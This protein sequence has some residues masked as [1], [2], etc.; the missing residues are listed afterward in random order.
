MKKSEDEPK[1]PVARMRDLKA[2]R[3]AARQADRE[4]RREERAE[5]RSA[6]KEAAKAAPT[7]AVPTAATADA[8]TAPPPAPKSRR[9]SW[10]RRLVVVPLIVLFLLVIACA[11]AALAILYGATDEIGARVNSYQSD[12]EIAVAGLS[13]EVTIRRDNGGVPYVYAD[14]YPDALFGQGFALGQDRLFQLELARRLA[15]GRLSEIAGSET[16]SA[17]RMAR[18]L[19]LRRLAEARLAVLDAPS[20]LELESFAA[21]VSAAIAARPEDL[22]LA[23]EFAGLG[24]PRAWT[25]LDVLSIVY[26]QSWYFASPAATAELIAQGLMERF[27]GDEN[28]AETFF[29]IS[30]NPDDPA[31]GEAKTI[32]RAESRRPFEDLDLNLRV[33]LWGQRRDPRLGAA[34][35]GAS[36]EG[37]SNNWAFSGAR[38]GTGRAIVANDPHLDARRLPGPWHPVGLITKDGVRAV[39]ANIGLPGIVVGRTRAA[40]FG[41]TIGYADAVDLF[42]EIVDPDRPGFYRDGADGPWLRAEIREE[43]IRIRDGDGFR[44]ETL[45]VTSTPRGPLAPALGLVRRPDRALSIRWAMASPE[46][47][48]RTRYVSEPLARA[49]G[50]PAVLRAA[51]ALAEV[52]LN[53]VAGDIDGRIGRRATGFLP[54][55]EGGDGLTPLPAAAAASAWR[56]FAAGADLPGEE[57]PEPGWTG[58]A[59]HFTPDAAFPH[60][61]SD[62]HAPSH[63][64]ERMKSLF[65][66][67]GRLSPRLAEAAQRDVLNLFASRLVPVIVAALESDPERRD[68]SALA[69]EILETWDRRD[70]ATAAAPLIFQ[71]II[72]EAAVS[73]YAP[74]L[75]GALAEKMLSARSFW[76]QRFENEIL[77]GAGPILA[78]AGFEGVIGRDVL[79]RQAT[80]AA[81]ERLATLHEG[82][83][84]RWRWGDALA[85]QFQGPIP[86]PVGFESVAGPIGARLA[87]LSGS[88]ETLDRARFSFLRPNPGRRGEAVDS[89]AGLRL[90]IDLADVEKMRATLAGG[91]VGRIFHRHLDDQ[92]DVWLEPNN[93]RYWWFSDERILEQTAATLT[94]RP[95]TP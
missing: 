64:Y 55:R 12:G 57:N 49:D 32:A 42:V 45:T 47:A 68:A 91:V 83:P 43:V 26:L 13:G 16:V 65:D 22:P 80:A 76:Q 93:R 11:A 15:A 20:R 14:S 56:G 34:A 60:P 81:M 6:A 24:A 36:A 79:L 88:A 72:R 37:G 50:A 89:V 95:K 48:A 92:V 67:P 53:M 61:Y 10:L 40:G 18:V 31:A 62:T 75:G 70:D 1:R 3:K 38:T 86:A 4:R 44:E 54:I 63:R 73:V 8:T 46:M 66:G 82:D 84:R 19:G 25:A 17:D 41:V 94:L 87:P 23:F 33:G 39:G 59:N 78:R 5:A 74:L 35:L 58:T 9:R 27:N 2:E 71:E 30:V 21:G 29:P 85:I 51:E 77:S 69:A 90:V 52:S 7:T 28:A